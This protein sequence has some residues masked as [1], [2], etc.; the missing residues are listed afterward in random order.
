MI[1]RR[2][3]LAWLA[4]AMLT[5]SK[6][7]AQTTRH[8]G[9]PNPGADDRL[10]PMP[11]SGGA[12]TLFLC[13]DVMTGRA[14][15]QIL[16]H[17]NDPRIHEPYLRDARDYI[18]LAEQLS[19]PIARR[20]PYEY[21]WGDALAELARTAPD[22][23]IVNLETSITTH[24][25]FA[26]KGINYRM[27]PRNVDV[28]TAAAI[29]CCALANNHVL[30]WGV[31]GL[32]ETLS[33]LQHAGIHSA[34]AGMNLEQ[35][36]A[37]ATIPVAGKG[38]VLVFAFGTEYSGIGRKWAA[39]IS[40]PGIDLLPDLSAST[41]KAIATRVA[42]ARKPGDIVVASIHWGGNWGF[43]I[44][45]AQRRFARGLIDQ[46]NV[47]VVHGHSSH[48]V[49]GL[50][51]Y[52]N[53]PIIYGCGDFLSDYEGIRGHR[54]FRPDLG[55]MYFPTFDIESGHLQQFAVV[56][57]RVRKFRIQRASQ[58][59]ADWLVQ[60]INRE[61]ESQ[62]VRIRTDAGANLWLEWQSR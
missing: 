11:G 52:R 46:A 51:V 2:D 35:A 42:R 3:F 57:T 18:V 25:N 4:G 16:P 38:R 59:E 55:M 60:T 54:E 21:V 15:D 13:G 30:D 34:G 44:P 7:A 50:E 6:A 45:A 26:P 48:H 40:R 62:G 39:A 36:Q 9:W 1:R 53:R 56:P 28:L 14:I 23:R 49:K 5:T 29:D 24:D 37:P 47:D 43:E 58:K 17:S 32:R 22:V 33:V 10:R 19:G 61:S 41:V 20:V 12:L 31:E 27:H 8:S